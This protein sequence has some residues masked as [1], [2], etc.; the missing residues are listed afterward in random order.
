MRQ[1]LK[2][3]ISAYPILGNFLFP[4]SCFPFPFS[5]ILILFPYK[6]NKVDRLGVDL[7]Y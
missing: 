7:C 6:V 3:Q 4:F 5:G 1:T 2:H